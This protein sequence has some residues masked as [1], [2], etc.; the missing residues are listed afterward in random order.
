LVSANSPRR[1]CTTPANQTKKGQVKVGE[2]NRDDKKFVRNLIK[3]CSAMTWW[4]RKVSKEAG[5][6]AGLEAPR[7]KNGNARSHGEKILQ[8]LEA[9]GTSRFGYGR[10]K[11]PEKTT[12][13]CQF[14]M[15]R[16][17][18]TIKEQC[19]ARANKDLQKKEGGSK[20]QVKGEGGDPLW[21]TEYKSGG[22]IC[23]FL[24]PQ[25]EKRN[26]GRIKKKKDWSSR[27]LAERETWVGMG[28]ERSLRRAS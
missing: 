15:K 23:G 7:E 10:K 2:V 19:S 16:Q 22:H 24:P 17:D 6:P 8:H 18:P 4:G 9:A 14:Q 20:G 11:G 3:C 5:I 27:G 25:V 28:Q 1:L 12:D 26:R 13:R 21:E